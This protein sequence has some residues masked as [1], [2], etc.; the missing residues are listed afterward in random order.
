MMPRGSLDEPEQ[1][2]ESYSDM[3]TEEPDADLPEFTQRKLH[4][5]LDKD[6]L[7]AELLPEIAAALRTRTWDH[8]L[9]SAIT[10]CDR[11]HFFAGTVFATV[12]FRSLMKKE[13]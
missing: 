11:F 12:S 8:Y 2:L 4:K 9:E 5:S 7:R 6:A 3:Y 10:M 1:E 13:H